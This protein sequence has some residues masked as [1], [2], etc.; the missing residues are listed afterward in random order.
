MFIVEKVAEEVQHHK[1]IKNLNNS[2]IT[3]SKV[4]LLN[5]TLKKSKF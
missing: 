5:N 1:Q 2:Q 4:N 3:G